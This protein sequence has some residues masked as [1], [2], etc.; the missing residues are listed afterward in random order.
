VPAEGPSAECF[1]RP[2]PRH[3][4]EGGPGALYACSLAIPSW[5]SR[6]RSQSARSRVPPPDWM[7][8]A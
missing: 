1:D 8:S 6:P 2:L 5:S 4:P 3:P 7:I